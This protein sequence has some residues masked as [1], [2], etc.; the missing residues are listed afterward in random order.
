[1]AAAALDRALALNPERGSR[2]GGQRVYPRAAQPD[3]F[4]RRLGL[5]VRPFRPGSMAGTLGHAAAVSRSS[6]P[7]RKGFGR[8]S[9]APKAHNPWPGRLTRCKISAGLGRAL[10]GFL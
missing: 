8:V 9:A 10:L 6:G 7:F 1:M 2:L 4:D 3:G 5:G